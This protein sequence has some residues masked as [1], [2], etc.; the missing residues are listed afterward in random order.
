MRQLVA[1]E[2]EPG[3]GFVDEIRR[4]FDDGDAVLPLDHRL[5]PPARRRLVEALRPSLRVVAPGER[6]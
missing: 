6:V 1:V 5:P 4:A 3:P 2:L